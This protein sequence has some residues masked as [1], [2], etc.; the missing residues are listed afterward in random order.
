MKFTIMSLLYG[1]LAG[2]FVTP[3]ETPQLRPYVG[4]QLPNVPAPLAC[5]DEPLPAPLPAVEEVE[6]TSTSDLK[7]TLP[8]ERSVALSEPPRPWVL[9][10]K[11]WRSIAES[12]V[13]ID[14]SLDRGDEYI[15]VRIV[16]PFG[17]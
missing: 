1:L 16:L 13:N 9:S 6:L 17:S 15:G 3:D 5:I 2:L 11:T 14:V 7:P 8:P 4:K 10:D 12:T